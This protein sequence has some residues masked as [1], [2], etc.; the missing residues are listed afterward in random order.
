MVPI[1][2]YR[3]LERCGRL[4]NQL[5]E[6]AST[7]GL[8]WAN[9]YE[10]RFPPTWSYRPYFSLPD[11]FFSDVAGVESSTLATHMGPNE[12]QYLQDWN[13][14]KDYE[15]AIRQFFAPSLLAHRMLRQFRA[16][17]ALP[18]PVLSVHVRRGDNVFDPGVPEKWRYMP[19]RDES[20]YEPAIK[21]LRPEVAS[22]ACFSDDIAWC[23]Q[24]I[25]ADYYHEGSPRPKDGTPEYWQAQPFD[26][27]DLFAMSC[28]QRHICSSSSYAWWSAF[29]S[30]DTEPRYPV[31]WYGPALA[32]IDTSLM[33]PPSWKA[34]PCS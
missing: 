14:F 17:N 16:F 26:C 31:P 15:P 12:R 4:G 27:L 13:L 9:G 5:F 2:T 23:R 29:L 28:A 22:V 20:Y 24:H 18:R 21:E 1:L 7:I 11:R 3:N 34:V 19:L 33:F 25:E 30:K 8:A 6:I 32:H 10:P